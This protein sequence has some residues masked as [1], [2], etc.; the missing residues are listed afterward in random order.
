MYGATPQSCWKTMILADGVRP[1]SWD[2]I[3]SSKETTKYFSYVSRTKNS[4]VKFG[5]VCFPL[6]SWWLSYSHRSLGWMAPSAA[7]VSVEL[8][9]EVFPL[10]HL[11]RV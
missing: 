11:K 7:S 2:I 10:A 1:V 6:P 9:F 5:S 4:W 3:I 8:G